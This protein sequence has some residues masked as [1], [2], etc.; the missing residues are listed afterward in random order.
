MTSGVPTY[1]EEAPVYNVHEIIEIWL[2][3]FIVAVLNIDLI[4]R[5]TDLF[6]CSNCS[7]FYPNFILCF[8]GLQ[9]I[10]S[11][12]YQENLLRV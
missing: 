4:C 6:K 9:F 12:Y 10:S 11:S 7:R 2:L 1:M 5:I 3:Y 8:F